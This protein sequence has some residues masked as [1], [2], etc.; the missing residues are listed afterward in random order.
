A[1]GTPLVSRVEP[2]IKLTDAN[3]PEEA[4]TTKTLA[5]QWTGSLHANATADYLLGIKANAFVRVSVDDKLVAQGWGNQIHMV[6]VHLERGRP[7]KLEVSYSRLVEGKPEAQVIWAPVNNAPDPAAVTAAKN[8]DVVVAV[9][10]IT[11]RLEGEEMPVDQ[12]GFSGGDRTNL[13]MPKPEEDL[14]QAVAATGKPLFVVPM[15]GR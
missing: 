14:V 13:E 5:V 15:N 12:P 10:G 8:A 11:S 1:K 6:Q 7:A 9:V 4:K 3:L 2:S